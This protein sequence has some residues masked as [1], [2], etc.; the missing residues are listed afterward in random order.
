MLLPLVSDSA[1]GE[2]EPEQDSPADV[3]IDLDQGEPE[4]PVDLPIDLDDELGD[5][6]IESSDDDLL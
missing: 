2:P 6:F 4:A 1:S 5:T 3:V